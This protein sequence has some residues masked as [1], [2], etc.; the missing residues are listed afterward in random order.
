MRMEVLRG[1]VGKM[2]DLTGKST[3]SSLKVGP[4]RIHNVEF[5]HLGY[6]DLLE[7]SKSAVVGF[8]NIKKSGFQAR[9]EE[10]FIS[11]HETRYQTIKRHER[12]GGPGDQMDKNFVFYVRD[13]DS[14]DEIF[15]L[16]SVPVESYPFVF[17]K[18]FIILIL[19][20]IFFAPIYS[21]TI[22]IFAFLMTLFRYYYF[23]HSSTVREKR[24]RSI[25]LL[26]SD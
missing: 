10:N 8:E 21:G 9:L 1:V 17:R 16:R 14:G 20:L 11:H 4:K 15:H 22:I 26:R 6:I 18:R 25:E 24:M 12:I 7:D 23:V 5:P 2:G 19:S 13:V 3:M